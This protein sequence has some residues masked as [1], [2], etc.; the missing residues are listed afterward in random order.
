MLVFYFL[1][2]TCCTGASFLKNNI[3]I[4]VKIKLYKNLKKGQ[5]LM[6]KILQAK[7]GF[8]TYKILDQAKMTNALAHA[9]KN[10]YSFIDTAKLY[11]TEELIGNALK[12][13]KKEP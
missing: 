4:Y 10:K 11:N 5:K 7:I 8:G 2:K 12:E 1:K 6:N 9:I 3:Y 13:L